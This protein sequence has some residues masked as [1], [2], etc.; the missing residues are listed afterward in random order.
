MTDVLEK[1]KP[2]KKPRRS[3]AVSL[4]DMGQLGRSA[5][6]RRIGTLTWTLAIT[7]WRLRF[8]GSV[9]GILWTLVKP[10]AFFGVIYVVFTQIASLD[11]NVEYY[12]PYI[13]FAMVLFN[14]FGEVTGM[15][16]QAFPFR[17]NLLRKM[18]FPPLVIPLSIAVTALLNLGMTLVAVVI[19]A[20]ISGVTPTWTWLEF[21]FLIILLTT[22][23]LGI[24]MSLSTLYVRFRDIQ[25]I[26]DVVG[27]IL[28]YMSA[29][30]YVATS[31]PGKYFQAFLC[32][33][34]AAINTEMRHVLLDHSAPSI[35]EAM[36]NGK[37]LIPSG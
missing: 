15:S 31:V 21:P 14:F 2:G 19:F 3:P 34:L 26:W 7:D 35:F 8:Y 36:P 10:F 6:L 20:L 9:L 22:L 13:L 11:T 25:P 23:A 28:F 4:P 1:P 29:V 12:A 17:E 5:E 33:P 16:V 27:Q 30:L 37:W 24:G 18:H 32:N